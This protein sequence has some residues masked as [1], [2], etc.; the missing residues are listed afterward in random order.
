MTG[1]PLVI[2]KEKKSIG[3][4][5]C[6][7]ENLQEC[8]G[9]KG[10]VIMY[11][12]LPVDH[13]GQRIENIKIVPEPVDIIEDGVNGNRFIIWKSTGAK[14][15]GPLVFYYDFDMYHSEVGGG[16]DL[17][18]VEP[19]DISSQEYQRNIISEGW[20]DISEDVKLK[21]REI[22]GAE[23]NPCLRAKAIYNWLAEN[24]HYEYIEPA[25]RGATKTLK[26]LKGD[27]GEFSALFV[28]MCRSLSIP[29]R[30]V[31]CN[32]MPSGGHQ[33][34]EFLLPP[35]G[36]IPVDATSAN[37]FRSDPGSAVC[38]MLKDL[39]GFSSS[40]PDWFFGNLYRDR[41]IVQIGENVNL[42]SSKVG[43]SSPVFYVLQPGG[44]EAIPSAAEFRGFSRP[45]VQCGTYVFG[46][47]REDEGYARRKLC[48]SFGEGF[49]QAKAFDKAAN[50]L[51]AS[52][53]D[54][55]K[56]GY[57][58]Y[59]LGEAQFGMKDY[60][61]AISSYSRTISGSGGS[62]KPVWDAM[63]HY[64]AGNSYD[65]LGERAKAMEEY[66]K[67]QASGISFENLQEKVSE[68]LKKP[69]IETAG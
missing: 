58:W 62:L 54:N 30:T 67:A 3:R 38:G 52:L 45:A 12:A 53:E 29:A 22:V 56:P 8:S 44:Q 61:A 14:K 28:A 43:G 57:T 60:R 24:L 36:W 48:Q 64:K 37:S 20:L 41:I 26:R 6:F 9:E 34:A 31:T 15:D 49:L 2:G 23:T 55:P 4:Y 68:C 42:S 63:A 66:S 13:L 19:Y 17:S 7:V 50:E 59:L 39:G 35:F 32:W 10:E 1:F 47:R 21:A 18:R 33:W 46:D 40:D 27:C 65:I 11:F 5:W 51:A 25:G 69:Y 16:I